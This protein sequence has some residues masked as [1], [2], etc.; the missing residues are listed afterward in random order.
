M[1][2]VKNLKGALP[3][4]FVMDTMNGLV[5]LDGAE[6]ITSVGVDSLGTSISLTNNP[7]LTSAIALTNT[8]YP[9]GTLQIVGN[10]NLTCVPSAWPATDKAGRT[11]S[12]GSCPTTLSCTAAT[13][14]LPAYTSGSIT[15]YQ[16]RTNAQ[17]L[18]LSNCTSID[19]LWIS[20]ADC[21]QVAWCGLQLQSITVKATVD[22]YSLQ[23]YNTPGISD[24]CGLKNLKG[25]LP[26]G[27]NVNNMNGLVSLDGAEGITSVGVDNHGTSIRLISNPILTSAIALTNIEYPAGTL[28]ITGN[29]NLTSVPCA[30]PAT[31]KGGRTIP[32]GSCPTTPAPTPA[33]G[34]IGSTG[35]DSQGLVAMDHVV[36]NGDSLCARVPELGNVTLQC[37]PHQIISKVQFASFGV[38]TGKCGSFKV[39]NNCSS[40]M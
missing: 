4:K 35:G 24:L 36:R 7:I 15:Y 32:H 25:A 5:S 28:Y 34:S 26:G 2:G 17:L 13:A 37:P 21:T 12:H 40:S 3:G 39:T 33:P 27:F 10:T 1:C 11:I 23:L 38:P 16:V 6:D 31:D 22:G 20:C 9:T 14:G 18:G 8:E 19:Y 30:W 29:T